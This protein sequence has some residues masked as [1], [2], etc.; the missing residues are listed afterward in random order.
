MDQEL[1]NNK[2][3]GNTVLFVMPDERLVYENVNV[4]VGAFHMP[5]LALAILSAIAK[6]NNYTPT[7]L[8][9]GIQKDPA[10]SL[11][12]TLLKLK[13]EYIGI[14]CTSATYGQAIQIANISKEILQGIKV[15]V[16]GTHVSSLIEETLRNKCFDYVFAGEADL[17]FAEFLR[18]TDPGAI[19]GIAFLDVEGRLRFRRNKDFLKNMDDLPPPDY[20]LYDL[21]E[22]R[23]SSLHAKNNPVVWLETSRGC[24]FNCQICNKVVHGQTFRPK[25]ALKVISDIE[26]LLKLGVQEFHITD[27]GF[28]SDVRRAEE[29]CDLIIEK[30]L[31]FTWACVNGIRVDRVNEGLLK[32]MRQ[33]GCYSISFGI[34]SGNQKVLDNLGKGI[35]LEQIRSSVGMAKAAGL[36][37]FGFF[38][39]GF[40]DDTEE[41]MRDTINFAKSLPLDLA[42][43]SIMMPFPGSPLYEKYNKEGLIYPAGDYR[44]FNTYMAPHK[45]YRHPSLN[46]SVVEAYQAKFYRSFYFSPGYILRRLEHAIRNKTIFNDIKLALKMEWFRKK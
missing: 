32:K 7:I 39:F 6:R 43:A 30:K 41:T 5:S 4:R 44:N 40:E 35:T 46:W 29:I 26:Y 36:E 15:L 17:S 38:I 33:A 16:G 10:A 8:D 37:V 45:V 12:D 31:K 25:S 23:V 2:F 3:G 24:P 13:P 9:L 42:K 28:T 18:G 22:Y 14:T 27:D 34:E 19:D 11:K 20:T 1:K 21:S